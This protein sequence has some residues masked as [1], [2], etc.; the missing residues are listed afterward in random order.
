[1]VEIAIDGYKY[2]TSQLIDL[3]GSCDEFLALPNSPGDHKTPIG[4]T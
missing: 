3:G 2:E 1:M 4:E